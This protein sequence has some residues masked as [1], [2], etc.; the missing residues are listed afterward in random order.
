MRGKRQGAQGIPDAETISGGL[1]G[2]GGQRK[3]RLL[4]EYGGMKWGNAKI[5]DLTLVGLQT[6]DLLDA[7]MIVLN[8]TFREQSKKRC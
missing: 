2:I 8:E 1:K 4:Q 7:V 6:G 5:K 3:A